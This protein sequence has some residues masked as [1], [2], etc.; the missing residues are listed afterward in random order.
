MACVSKRGC[1]ALFVTA[2]PVE[3]RAMRL[4]RLISGRFWRRD[5]LTEDESFECD[6]NK[7]VIVKGLTSDTAFHH[8]WNIF[9]INFS[10]CSHAAL[11]Q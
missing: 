9:G 3:N 10:C 2:D 4:F 5:K 6:L 1:L 11:M 7:L 8:L